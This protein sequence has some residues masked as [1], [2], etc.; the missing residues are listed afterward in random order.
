ML[1]AQQALY[2]AGGDIGRAQVLLRKKGILKAAQKS[3]RAVRDGVVASYVH[4][5]KVGVLVEVN[6][7][8]DFVAKTE[9][10][11]QFSHEIALQIA[12][13]APRY[14]S[15]QLV[16]PA[17]VDQERAIIAEEVARQNKPKELSEKIIAGKLERFFEEICLLEQPSIKDPKVKVSQLLTDVIARLGENIVIARFARYQ[18]G[19]GE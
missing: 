15:R 8:T 9:D 7:E 4:A 17:V 18:L 12:G 10:F 5:G 3:S 16:P 19:E 2:E 1:E 11:R 13:A 6:C 14:I